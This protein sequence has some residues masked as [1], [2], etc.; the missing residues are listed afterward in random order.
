[1][2]PCMD[3]DDCR[4]ALGRADLIM[5]AFDVAHPTLSLPGIAARVK[6]P[7]TSVRRTVQK[8]VDLGWL[9]RHD[10]RFAIGSRMFEIGG[11][12]PVQNRLRATALPHLEDLY[13]ATHE[14]V[15]LGVLMG[16]QVLYVEKL[17]GHRPA[18]RLSRVGGR[19]PAHCTAI[20]KVLTAY[21]GPGAEVA[22]RH[23]GLPPR[24]PATITSRMRLESELRTIR[25]A[26]VAFDREECENG[27]VCVAAPVR[28]GAGTPAAAIS[29]TAATGRV[30]LTRMAAVVLA[31]AH[32]IARELACADGRSAQRY[33][34]VTSTGQP[35][36]CTG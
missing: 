12:S 11:L 14:T 16:S 19:M 25:G 35:R 32:R 18:T 17:S 29:V 21:S 36:L 3:T 30:Q 34:G 15:H 7:R 20:G 27:L 2:I 23:T 9:E 24:T 5:G 28:V 6:L 1:V 10:D 22:L 8:L 4:S 13:E 33:S 31:S 26:G